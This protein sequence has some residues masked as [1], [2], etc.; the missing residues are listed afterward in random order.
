MPEALF[1]VC[2]HRGA[3][4]ACRY[5]IADHPQES[6]DEHL[7]RSEMV[8]QI[9]AGQ[10]FYSAPPHDPNSKHR[11][12]PVSLKRQSG[13]DVPATEWSYDEEV[14]LSNKKAC[15]QRMKW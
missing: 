12:A 7:D 8:R 15:G 5:G 2:V 6:P 10:T 11:W 4:G 9:E 14:Y 13:E 3:N 1:V